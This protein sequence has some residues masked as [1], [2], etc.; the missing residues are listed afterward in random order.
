MRKSKRQHQVDKLNRLLDRIDKSGVD[1]RRTNW[2]WV[3]EKIIS[4]QGGDIEL[5]SGG[6]TRDEMILLNGMWKKH[7]LI[8]I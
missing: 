2:N 4:V 7:S 6:L 8:K 5:D 1:F 3:R